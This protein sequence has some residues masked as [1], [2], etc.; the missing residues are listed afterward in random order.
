M[1][2]SGKPCLEEALCAGSPCVDDPLRDPLTVELQS[3]TQ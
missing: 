3:R 2:Q 1:L